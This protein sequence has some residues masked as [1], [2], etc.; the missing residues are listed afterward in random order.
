MV[1]AKLGATWREIKKAIKN[2]EIA[3]FIDPF[4]I[5]FIKLP[6]FSLMI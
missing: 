3:L 6:D 2:V 1:Y 4:K 5:D